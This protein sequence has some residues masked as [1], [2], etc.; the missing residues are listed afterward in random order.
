MDLFFWV[1]SFFDLGGMSECKK[2]K[3]LGVNVHYMYYA[4]V[5]V[6]SLFHS[7]RLILAYGMW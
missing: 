5:I 2:T 7:K 4:L 1:E 6:F 3:V